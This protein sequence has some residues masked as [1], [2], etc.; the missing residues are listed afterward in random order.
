[1][2]SLL[3]NVQI[4]GATSSSNLEPLEASAE[5]LTH[6]K[7]NNVPFVQEPNFSAIEDEDEDDFSYD[8][9]ELSCR[10]NLL[11]QISIDLLTK[12][13]RF[14]SRASEGNSGNKKSGPDQDAKATP[15]QRISIFRR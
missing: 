2:G 7:P 12:T 3:A 1:M 9:S 14:R 8:R 6:R 15:D 5:T 11:N 4:A 13:F 10:R